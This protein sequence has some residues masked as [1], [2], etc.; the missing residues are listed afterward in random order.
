MANHN[1]DWVKDRIQI[2]SMIE[3]LDSIYD[4]S[5]EAS[6]KL[7]EHSLEVKVGD[8]QLNIQLDRYN[9]DAIYNMLLSLRNINTLKM[10]SE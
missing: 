4:G 5:E 6:D 1:Y 10:K 8:N 3:Y 2:I 7:K 9:F